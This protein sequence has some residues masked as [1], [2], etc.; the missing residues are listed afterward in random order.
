LS[1]PYLEWIRNERCV[2]CG[3]WE[4]IEAAHIGTG[5]MGTKV[6]DFRALPMCAYCHR[7]SDRSYHNM[8]N[9]YSF[10]RYHRINFK[11]QIITHLAR[12]LLEKNKDFDL[13]NFTIER[14]IEEIENE[15]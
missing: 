1:K 9:T 14:L 3:T 15:N 4:L 13:Q 7:I 6:D 10:E 2:V 5:G 8:G 12:Y 11:A